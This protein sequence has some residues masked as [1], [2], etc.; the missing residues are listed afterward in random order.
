MSG[1]VTVYDDAMTHED[2]AAIASRDPAFAAAA[3]GVFA[4]IK[5]EAAKH[6]KTGRFLGSIS[7]HQEKTDFHIEEDGLDY[8]W[9]AEMGHFQGERGKPGRKWVKG[10]GIF[11]NVV[12]RHGGF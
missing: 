8:D 7:M 5:A 11:R 2:I 9:N 4:E 6:V 3:S 1:D 10:L 12:R